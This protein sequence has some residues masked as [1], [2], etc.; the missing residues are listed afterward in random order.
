MRYVLTQPSG[1]GFLK[2]TRPIEKVV[3]KSNI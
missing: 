1:V 2:M 3:R